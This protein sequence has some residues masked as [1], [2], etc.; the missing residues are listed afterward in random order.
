MVSKVFGTA[1]GNLY[2]GGPANVSWIQALDGLDAAQALRVPAGLPHSIAGVVAH[3]QF[4]QE[5]LLR[6]SAGENPAAPLHADG[7]WP[8]PG[9][10]EG[11]KSA[12][13]RDV[14]AL[15]ERARDTDF[16]ETLDSRGLP[17]GVALT[18]VAG[19]GVYHLG[20]VVTIRQALGLWPPPGGGDTW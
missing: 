16:V 20:Q 8:E 12:F 9:D 11:L 2:R 6:H 10:W 7:G 1:V 17:Y 14:E 13:L 19:H 5:H 4:W 18:N 3:V 15:R